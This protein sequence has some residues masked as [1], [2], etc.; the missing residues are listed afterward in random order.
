VFAQLTISPAAPKDR[1][2][3]Y[4]E[5]PANYLQ[6]RYYFVGTTME[7]M[8]ITAWY[9]EAGTYFPTGPMTP[10]SRIPLGQLPA[11]DY[12]VEIAI[13]DQGTRGSVPFRVARRTGT[14]VP[15]F[16][17]TDMWWNPQQSGWGVSI[18]QHASD[19]LFAVWFVYGDDRKPQWYVMPGGS[20][21]RNSMFYGPV[22]RTSGPAFSG[23]FDP[24]E[25]GV[26]QVGTATFDFFSGDGGQFRYT[27]DG[28]QGGKIIQRQPF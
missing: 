18:H 12:S 8:K 27:I 21:E 28:V 24:N 11:G 17:Y 22:Y 20:W 14:Q 19:V 10:A 7:A 16:N 25:V 23:A 1:D 4:L 3:I 5:L 13:R 9:Q 2:P 26:V 6:D 15:M